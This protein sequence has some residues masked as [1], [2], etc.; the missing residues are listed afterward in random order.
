MRRDLFGAPGQEHASGSG[1]RTPIAIRRWRVRRGCRL[2]RNGACASPSAG[3]G[4]LRGLRVARKVVV[5]GYPCGPAAFELDPRLYRDYQSRKLFAPSWLEEHM[6]HPF[7]DRDCHTQRCRQTRGLIF[8]KRAEQV[9]VIRQNQPG[10]RGNQEVTLGVVSSVMGSSSV[11]GRSRTNAAMAWT[12]ASTGFCGEG[13][14]KA[15]EQARDQ[16][17]LDHGR[18]SPAKTL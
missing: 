3:P 17:A 13:S 9:A 6:L 16:L 14:S 15:P 11:P 1:I 7:P 4:C 5:F 10:S 12:N 2:G 18:A 8:V